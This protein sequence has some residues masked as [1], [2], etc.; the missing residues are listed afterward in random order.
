MKGDVEKPPINKLS[1]LNQWR[2]DAQH[3]KKEAQKL[4]PESLRQKI[5]ELKLD[6]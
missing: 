6:R 2:E 1:A 4:Q 5:A 3:L